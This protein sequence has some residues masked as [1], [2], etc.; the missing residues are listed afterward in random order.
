MPA[1]SLIFLATWLLTLV[2]ACAVPIAAD[3]DDSEANRVY[4][5][6]DRAN[7]AAGKEPDP[8][9]EGKWRIDVARDDVPRALA[10]L[11][12]EELPRRRPTG[13]LDAV[14]K[15]SLVP[16]EAAERA[17]IALGIAGDLERTLEDIDGVLSAHVHLS[18]P[19]SPARDLTAAHGSAGVL[20]EHRGSTPPVSV[21]S[22]QRLVA[23]AVGGVLP[24]DV[25]VV[26]VARAAPASSG[27][28][29]SLAHLGPIAVAR[30]SM[31]ELQAALAV[32]AALVATLCAV[33]IVLYS[34]LSRANAVVTRD[35]PLAARSS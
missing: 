27:D 30:R 16:S 34:R 4:V 14:G 3:L 22:V 29:Q 11:R 20:I 33:V 24:T 23:G 26:L 28:A 2:S 1:R 8:A 6:L 21:E 9:A 12:E 17:Q 32:L 10:L 5:V 25:S 35:G 13:V 18:M 19:A 31:R 15:G 7:V